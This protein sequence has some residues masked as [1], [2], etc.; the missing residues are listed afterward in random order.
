MGQ[1]EGDATGLDAFVSKLAAA[2]N[3]LTYSTYLGGS[4]DDS[5]RAIAV[6]SAGAAYVA[7]ETSSA[8]FNTLGELEGAPGDGG[9]DVFVSKLVA[10][11]N[12]VT[13]STYLGGSADDSARAI[14]VDS[15]GAA[16]VAGRTDST[17]FD[18]AGPIETDETG[19]DAFILKLTSDTDG[20]GVTD[21]A[22]NCPNNANADQANNDG[23]GL[24]DVCDADDD[25]DTVADGADN[26]PTTANADQANND[27][28]A[29][30]DVC[31]AD[32]DNDTL[33]DG[34][35]NCPAAANADQ[36]NNDADAQGD[37][38]DADDDNDT[39]ADTGDACPTVAAATGDGCPVVTDTDTDGDGIANASDRCPQAAGPGPDGCPQV[40]RTL[41]LRFKAR[42]QVF[43]GKLTS[44][45]DTPVCEAGKKVTV[46]EKK[47]GRD[48][49][50]GKDTTN[51]GG[52]YEVE[53]RGRDGKY[54]AT[55]AEADEAPIGVC[56]GAKSKTLKL[57]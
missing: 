1:I 38:C 9:V 23:D 48:P 34:A 49:K 10:A 18:T 47:P 57:S 22:D 11:G 24:G 51:D 42:A 39:V 32:D 50:V 15:A 25:N 28:D 6:D 7:G 55:V 26:C 45:P 8:D 3:A 53:D 40:A 43:K 30:G 33:T 27:A 56:L 5:A 44:T 20:D 36:A 16:Y 46:F 29:Q 52:A 4:A 19:L 54:Y 2:G 31:D 35:D 37:V 17:D 12:A 13:Y 21:G 41:S 14:A